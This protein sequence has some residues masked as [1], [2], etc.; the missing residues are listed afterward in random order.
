MVIMKR[1]YLIITLLI[2]AFLDLHSQ[3]TAVST[4]N[5]DEISSTAQESDSYS[6]TVKSS[7]KENTGFI[8]NEH[9][10][11]A[12]NP[13]IGNDISSPAECHD[14]TIASGASLI[15]PAGKALTVYGD[16]TNNSGASGIVIE[17]SDAGD[18]SLIIKSG[19]T[20][21]AT[22]KRYFTAGEWHLISSPV[23]NATASVLYD[24]NVD[25]WLTEHDESQTGDASW[26][27]ITDI[28]TPLTQGKGYAYWIDGT[29]AQT[30]TFT[31][32]IS[33]SSFSPAIAFTDASHG[34]NLVG[35]PYTC[36]IDWDTSAWTKTNLENSVW[37][38]DNDYN[39]GDYRPWNGSTG[40][41]TDGIIPKGQG[42]FVKANDA[43]P[44]L[45]IPVEARIHHNQA[46][47][48]AGKISELPEL[49]LKVSNGNYGNVAW[50]TFPEQGTESFD[51]G[52]DCSKLFGN[53]NAS[54]LYLG[55]EEHPLS[56]NAL[57]PLTPDNEKI[58]P[59]KLKVAKDM[60][61]QIKVLNINQLDDVKI[62]L[63]DL[64]TGYLQD[65]KENPIYVFDANTEDDINRFAV[66]FYYSPNSVNNKTHGDNTLKVFAYQ[67]KLYIRSN[68]NIANTPGTLNVYDIT[69]KLKLSKHLDYGTLIIVPFEAATNYYIV[70]VLRGNHVKTEKIFIQ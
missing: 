41:L 36:A 18:G 39:N 65:L 69:G 15:I 49:K 50:I 48:K 10:S 62:T 4:K 44:A 70:Q 34:Y 21:E 23:S 59:L 51:N 31:G 53:K 60:V 55:T 33:G 6:I 11:R 20:T 66:H 3:Q 57:P 61:H 19:T 63:E 40:D 12:G 37:V 42:F 67:N 32:T 7:Q 56:I 43:S 2:I 68:E 14:L 28:N 52:F 1:T 26:S 16:I 38:W 8:K 54:Q 45:T 5:G 29:T 58:V 47:Y 64:K 13:T 27:Y 17:S 25:S 9:S 46:Y 22:V 35:N 30:K 24:V